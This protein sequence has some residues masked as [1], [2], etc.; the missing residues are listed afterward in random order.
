MCALSKFVIAWPIRDK[1][2]TTIAEGILEHVFLSYGACSHP[3]TDHDRDFANELRQE[4]CRIM[5]VIEHNTSPTIRLV[6]VQ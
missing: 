5:G 4:V 2:A 6:M 3:L 1:I